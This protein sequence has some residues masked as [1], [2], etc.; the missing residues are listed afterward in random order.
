[1]VPDTGKRDLRALLATA[2]ALRARLPESAR[3]LHRALGALITD[4][5]TRL[6]ALVPWVRAAELADLRGRLAALSRLGE[7]LL[8]LLE[9]A[10][11]WERAEAAF[12]AE[13]VAQPDAALAG[14]FTD[15]AEPRLSRLAGA[16]VTVADAG[17]LAE[18]RSALAQDSEQRDFDRQLFDLFVEAAGRVRPFIDQG[19]AA[20]IRTL[21]D[22]LPD[23]RRR[24]LAAERPSAEL[25][26]RL[27]ELVAAA[28]ALADRPKP[29]QLDE[30][31]GLIEGMAAWVE[32]LRDGL[33]PDAPPQPE[34]D[35]AERAW[36]EVGAA[37][38]SLAR[39]WQQQEEGVFAALIE[40]AMAVDAALLALA[41]AEQAGLTRRLERN[42]ALLKQ[43]ADAS[44]SPGLTERI[45]EL[46]AATPATPAAFQL[47]REQCR[48][49]GDDFTAAIGADSYRLEARRAETAGAIGERLDELDR[50]P[51]GDD[52]RADW[53]RLRRRLEG[54]TPTAAGALPV[55][56]LLVQ[57]QALGALHAEV[58]ALGNRAAAAAARV[59]RRRDWLAERAVRLLALRDALA[60]LGVAPPPLAAD[61][62]AALGGAG[63]GVGPA[64]VQTRREFVGWRGRLVRAESALIAAVLATV[65]GRL[66]RLGPLHGALDDD[67]AVGVALPAMLAESGWPTVA[68]LAER[69]AALP[70]AEQT[71]HAALTVQAQRLRM[72]R[73][74]L[75]ERLAQ[76]DAAGWSPAERA[77]VA[78]LLVA[79]A[80]EAAAG[81]DPLALVPLLRGQGDEAEALL[82]HLVQTRQALDQLA[83][84]LSRR[85]ATLRR[86]YFELDAGPATGGVLADRAW[87]LLQPLPG[88]LPAP[89]QRL[90]QLREVERLLGVLSR[91]ARALVALRLERAHGRLAGQAEGVVP[92]A[93]A[94]PPA[95][96]RQLYLQAGAGAPEAA[97]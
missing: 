95:R 24:L 85:L 38:N 18:V 11:Q 50:T 4:L 57:L 91:H 72:A 61:E 46:L 56:D 90:A 43:F 17:T 52:T 77:A 39:H 32:V 48:R 69:V 7:D 40:R 5:N 6:N 51:L 2:N 47:W 54:L 15:R 70:L 73:P 9:E 78:R 68:T 1:M 26:V 66:A 45:G 97:A 8:A 49:A 88:I 96:R 20:P 55:T 3:A 67:L 87:A 94:P 22:A 84:G 31:F 29:P 65:Q 71:L 64:L 42:R 35:R 89:A 62:L 25:V 36:R 92:E 79:L 74:A 14:W 41:K 86:E 83:A 59:A 37:F 76:A 12:G 28:R 19:G 10:A 58:T 13:R 53:L 30:C 82:A 34:L 23:L 33:E 81:E 63:I 93:V 60:A 21:A 75:R 16:A 44:L 27:R 80:D